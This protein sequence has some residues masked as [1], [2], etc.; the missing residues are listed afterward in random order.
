MI[1]HLLGS[2]MCIL[3]LRKVHFCLNFPDIIILYQFTFA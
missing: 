1:L 2:G 3:L